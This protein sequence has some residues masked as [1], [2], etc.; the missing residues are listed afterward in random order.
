MGWPVEE[1]YIHQEKG[2]N[3]LDLSSWA[4]FTDRVGPMQ[5]SSFFFFFY[6]K[7]TAFYFCKHE[8]LVSTEDATWAGPNLKTQL[9]QPNLTQNLHRAF[10]RAGWSW[11]MNQNP[12]RI[13][14]KLRLVGPSL[15]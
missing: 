9:T 5:N 7:K 8:V 4:G 1:Q 10:L 6:E 13:R 15:I 12:I 3:V 2:N 11:D 14:V